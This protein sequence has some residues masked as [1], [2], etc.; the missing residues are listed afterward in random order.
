MVVQ[1]A[2]LNY[3]KNGSCYIYIH[4][5]IYVWRNNSVWLDFVLPEMHKGAGQ[6]LG[7]FAIHSSIHHLSVGSQLG[8]PGIIGSSHCLWHRVCVCVFGHFAGFER[9]V[10]AFL[11]FS[12][13]FINEFSATAPCPLLGTF[14][15]FIFLIKVTGQVEVTFLRFSQVLFFS[16]S[17]P[18][19]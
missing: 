19:S 15:P 7:K 3:G 2:R 1:C 14:S 12:F 6:R 11:C 4:T 17:L 5:Y 8:M 18:W 16:F 13:N 9:S 10:A